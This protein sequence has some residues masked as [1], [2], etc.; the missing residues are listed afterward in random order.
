MEI[1][2]LLLGLLVV[3]P[4]PTSSEQ[5]KITMDDGLHREKA[6]SD[7]FTEPHNSSRHKT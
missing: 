1:S 4:L 6:L 2:F 3:V 7:T 5:F